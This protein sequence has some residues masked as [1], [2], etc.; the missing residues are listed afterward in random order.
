MASPTVPSRGSRL[1]KG[2]NAAVMVRRLLKRGEDLCLLV[3]PLP[4]GP[5]PHRPTVPRPPGRAAPASLP[6]D[7]RGRASAPPSIPARLGASSPLAGGPFEPAAR[8]A[9][10]APRPPG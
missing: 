8:A 9:G 2:D 7:P 6:D 4:S 5:G 10:P 3:Q 1:V